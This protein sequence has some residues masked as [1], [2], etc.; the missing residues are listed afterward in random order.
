[1]TEVAV[2]AELSRTVAFRMLK[3]LE[4]A[5][6]VQVVQG[7]LRYEAT[8]NQAGAA[9]LGDAL[10]LLRK[11]SI[12]NPVEGVSAQ[13]LH[14]NSSLSLPQIHSALDDLHRYRLVDPIG[15]D[16]WRISPAILGYAQPLL[17]GS[18]TLTALRPIMQRLSDET[19]ETITFFRE[20]DGFQV[21][22][23]VIS[24]KQPLSYSLP[25][26]SAHSVLRGAAGR[27]WLSGH[28][29]EEVTRIVYRLGALGTH[30]PLVSLETLIEDAHA[31]RKQGYA[32]CHNER[33]PN[34]AAT[35]VP[36]VGPTG[37]VAGVLSVM[38]PDSRL[39]SNRA[40]IIGSRMA[41]LTENLFGATALDEE[42]LTPQQG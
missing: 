17:R 5:G 37:R 30:E 28:K 34:A 4:T 12:S 33:I 38:A 20:T 31:F 36:V 24:C 9:S 27:A 11:I 13:I 16:H 8:V 3:T 14:Q 35:A 21:V 22:T 1:M 15:A 23:E 41:K 6:Y 26:G 25:L 2:K 10:E 18:P 29:T 42:A 39:S 40:N 7:G 19:G 32:Y